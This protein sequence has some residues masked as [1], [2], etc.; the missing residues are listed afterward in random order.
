MS[1]RVSVLPFFVVHLSLLLMLL[2]G[3]CA[4]QESR[5]GVQGSVSVNGAPLKEGRIR[6]VPQSDQPTAGTSVGIVSG[7]YVVSREEG[8]L[9][10]EYRVEIE[11]QPWGF[12]FDD[13]AALIAYAQ[14]YKKTPPTNRIPARY[15]KASEL[16]AVIK[17][18]VENHLDYSLEIKGYQP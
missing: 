17:P 1:I 3:G 2:T 15:N 4:Q 12:A 9:P 14:K 11:D 7:K 13:E 5:W 6:F 10:G 16:T 18:D 8:L